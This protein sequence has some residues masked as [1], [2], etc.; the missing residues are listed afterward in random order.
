MKLDNCDEIADACTSA[1]YI[2]ITHGGIELAY[3]YR[4]LL[5]DAIRSMPDEDIDRLIQGVHALVHQILVLREEA[6]DE[7]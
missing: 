6:C 4:D 3:Q 2:V 5:A 1:A 7:A